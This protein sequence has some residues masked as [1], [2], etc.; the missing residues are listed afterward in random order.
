MVD[1]KAV[2]LAQAHLYGATANDRIVTV[3]IADLDL[4]T[5]GQQSFDPWKSYDVRASTLNPSGQS[6]P[7]Y[8][9]LSITEPYYNLAA[10]NV[11]A[12]GATLAVTNYAQSWWY[13]RTHP[14]GDSACHSVAT[15]PY[16]ASLS[17]LTPGTPYT[18][19]VYDESGCNA[20]DEK[21]SVSFTT[22]K[23][24]ASQVTATSAALSLSNWS[25]AWW[26][27]GNQS[28]AT[29]TPVAAGT[30]TVNLGS[31][32]AGTPY[33]YTTYGKDGCGSADAI[34]SATFTTPPLAKGRDGGQDFNTLN[35]ADNDSPM[36][37]WSNG[38]TTWVADYLDGK[39][40]AYKTSDGSRDA[41]KDFNTLQAAGNTRSTGIWSDGATLWVAD[42][43]DSKLYAYNVA[44]KARD[45]AKDFSTLQAAGNTKPT[46]IWS[47]G[48]TMWVA[49]SD[50]AKLYAYQ[51][52]PRLTVSSIAA[53]TAT[54][55]LANR[56]GAWHYQADS[57]PDSTCQG[58]VNGASEALSGLTAGASYAYTAYSA[59]GCNSADKVDTVT[60]STARLTA[61][62]L[63]TTTAT[64]TLSGHTGNWWVKQ[65]SPA[66]G[67][68]TA[69][70]A[71]F[72][73]ALSGLNS[74]TAYDYAAYRDSTCTTLIATVT[75]TTHGLAAGSFSLTGATLT[76]TGHT[77]NW[78]LKKT[79][80]SAGTA[81]EAA[82]PA[83]PTGRTPSPASPAARAT[84]TRRTATAVARP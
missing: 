11:T 13:E 59:S 12:R 24:A 1:G 22:P 68:C 78:W 83:R 45:A 73:H 55:T 70:E 47:D 23:P 17:S 27:K 63:A 30:T 28:G 38:A 20:V 40:Y 14:S 44:T 10:S 50:D 61:G 56:T 16:T 34:G 52:P 36:G 46:G 42:D 32:T 2:D 51:L 43:T 3:T 4:D 39:I 7:T 75:F 29:C 69:G 37:I 71:D 76:L 21:G 25:A 60:I 64:L 65:T 67:T 33:T 57:G 58:P 72:S 18:Y 53:S 81:G 54:L 19:T 80:P 31:L 8:P 48:A 26:Y 41:A 49:D 66:G 82:R 62:S 77:G 6:L 9:P 84:P 15:S 79:A 35:A 74:V 5:A